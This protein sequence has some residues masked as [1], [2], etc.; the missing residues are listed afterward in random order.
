MKVSVSKMAKKE[1]VIVR[2]IRFYWDVDAKAYSAQV[3][4]DEIEDVY[5]AGYHSGY[6]QGRNFGD[7]DE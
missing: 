4:P 6:D 1:D 2:G 7:A 3:S 5:D